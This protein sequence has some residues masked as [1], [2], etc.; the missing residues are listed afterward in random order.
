MTNGFD[1]IYE[2]QIEA[3]G[4]KGDVAFAIST[5]GNSPNV[6]TAVAK[7][8]AMGIYTIGL[9]EGTVEN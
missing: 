1:R 2:R 7:A 3:L 4:Q 6:L 9:P 8:R 5:S